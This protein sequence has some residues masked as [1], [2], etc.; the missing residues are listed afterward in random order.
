[1]LPQLHGISSSSGLILSG[2]PVAQGIVNTKSDDFTQVLNATV[3]DFKGFRL[4]D[5]LLRFR[6]TECLRFND[7]M[8]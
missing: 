3:A 5:E 7:F 6:D 1:M 2:F 8:Y 4:A